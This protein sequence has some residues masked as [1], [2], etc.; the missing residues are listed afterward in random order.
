[1]IY[2]FTVLLILSLATLCTACSTKSNNAWVLDGGSSAYFEHR[3]AIRSKIV[4]AWNASVGAP[5]GK[6]NRKRCQSEV[7]VVINA[8]GELVN[9][10]F[11]QKSK[12]KVWNDE[13]E[14]AVKAASPYGPMAAAILNSKGLVDFTFKFYVSDKD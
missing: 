6:A 13:L 3:Q 1:M 11:V 14:R 5:S 4:E 2:R 10:K 9:F 8:D 12:F 7:Q